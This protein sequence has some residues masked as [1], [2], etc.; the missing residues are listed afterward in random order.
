MISTSELQYSYRWSNSLHSAFAWPSS[1][2]VESLFNKALEPLDSPFPFQITVLL[3]LDFDSSILVA[4]KKLVYIINSNLFNFDN[5]KTH[6]CK[7]PDESLPLSAFY[8]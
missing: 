5:P 4:K 8:K 6:L 1:N 2:Y 7:Q 3:T